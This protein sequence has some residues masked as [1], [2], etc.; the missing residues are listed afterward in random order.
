MAN[1]RKF[2]EKIALLNQK[3]AEETAAFEAIMREVS[4]VTSRVRDFFYFHS[5]TSTEFC[6]TRTLKRK[7]RTSSTTSSSIGWCVLYAAGARRPRYIDIHIL[8]TQ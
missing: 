7:Q 4:D 3:Q 6:L 2:S 8:D 1:P 5:D